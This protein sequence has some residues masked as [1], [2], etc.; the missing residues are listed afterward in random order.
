MKNAIVILI[1]NDWRDIVD[2]NLCLETLHL[3]VPETIQDAEI[4]FYHEAG[5]E[6][7]REGISFP[8]GFE[9]R[10]T[11]YEV[12]LNV[13]KDLILKPGI[14]IPDFVPHPTHSNGPIAFGHP[15]FSIGYRSMC[16]F[17]GAGMF[18]R[19][20]IQQFEFVMRLDTDSR[21]LRGTGK[22]LFSWAHEEKIVYG[23]IGSANQW[24]HFD[25]IGGL[26]LNSLAY[27]FKSKNYLAFFKSLFI[28]RGRVFYTNFEISR[29]SFFSSDRWQNYFNYLDYSG[30]FYTKRWGD[31]ILRYMGVN[32]L[33]ERKFRKTLPPGFVYQHGGIFHTSARQSYRPHW[34]S[35]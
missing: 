16:R 5:F 24:D 30:G 8:P 17:F 2:L 33:V 9:S 32:A 15:G 26:K 18:L 21:F 19:P 27:F 4:L 29:V 6:T 13:P 35:K 28:R 23:F 3:N 7:F 10:S 11:F 20:E 31:H 34:M 25:L 22:S 12:D 14:V 1:R